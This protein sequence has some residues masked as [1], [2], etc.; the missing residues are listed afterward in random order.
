MNKE[1]LRRRRAGDQILLTKEKQEIEEL[2]RNFLGKRRSEIYANFN[3]YGR[4]TIYTT[5]KYKKENNGEVSPVQELARK[6]IR[7]YYNY[8]KEFTYKIMKEIECP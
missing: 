6:I 1:L 5:V 4:I 3:I 2:L 8:A 7:N